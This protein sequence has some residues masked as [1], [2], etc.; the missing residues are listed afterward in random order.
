LFDL[1][2]ELGAPRSLREIG[3]PED[4]LDKAADIAVV[5]PYWNPRPIERNAIRAL[6]Q[7]AYDGRRPDQASHPTTPTETVSV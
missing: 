1:A 4:G 6:L 7:D 2:G 5:S 3:M